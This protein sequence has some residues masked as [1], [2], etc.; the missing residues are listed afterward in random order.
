MKKLTHFLG[1]SAFGVC[2][3]L[4]KKIGL[5]TDVVR[6]HFIYAS[7]ATFGSP[8]IFYLIVAFWLNLRKYVRQ[9]QPSTK[10]G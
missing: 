4:G 3:Y 5:S 6:M 2:A 10:L 9:S 1:R 7:F 8:V